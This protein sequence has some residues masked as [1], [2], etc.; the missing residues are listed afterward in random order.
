MREPRLTNSLEWDGRDGS[1]GRDGE[2]RLIRDV[3]DGR[4]GSDASGTGRRGKLIRDVRDGRDGSDA[5]GKI[6]RAMPSCPCHLCRS[7]L[8]RPSRLF[9]ARSS[10]RLTVAT[11]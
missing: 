11:S 1:D 10:K 3:R 6:T 5:R 8:S 2:K 7:R 9:S 4:D